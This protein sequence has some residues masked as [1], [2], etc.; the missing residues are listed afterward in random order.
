LNVETI[1]VTSISLCS[2]L[3]TEIQSEQK[4]SASIQAEV[5]KKRHSH[6]LLQMEMQAKQRRIEEESELK[7]KEVKINDELD[8]ES[9]KLKLAAL[10]RKMA[11]A[12]FEAE[13]MR[14]VMKEKED[15]ILEFLT[16][17]KEMDVDMTKFMTTYGGIHL[18]DKVLGNS[19]M[20]RKDESL[21]NE[22]D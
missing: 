12:K 22:K 11:L 21:K 2:A 9:H 20:L 16:K 1:Q 14:T 5:A 8:L 17:V 18:A 4:L 13:G 19:E 7:K 6:Q 10:D 3:K 15:S